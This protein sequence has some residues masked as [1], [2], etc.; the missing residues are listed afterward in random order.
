MTTLIV[1]VDDE[2]TESLKKILNDIPYVHS[3][4]V[5]SHTGESE[6]STQAQRIKEI[7]AAAKGK[8]LFGDIKNPAAWQR[9][10]RSASF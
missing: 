7:L 2:R 1:T 5:E 6:P 3:V 4:A 9:E 10:I 8:N